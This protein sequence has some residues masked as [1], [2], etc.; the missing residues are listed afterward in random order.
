MESFFFNITDASYKITNILK[1]KKEHITRV[2]ISNGIVYLDI[3]LS[4]LHVATPLHVENLD[5]M[6]AITV[7]KEGSISLKDNITQKIYKI[8]SNSINLFA[9]S[10]QNLSIKINQNEKIEMFILFIADFILKRYLSLNK[11]E[12]INILY[13]K[14]QKELSLELID[15]RPTDALSLYII[16]KILAS[17]SDEY[18]NSIKCEHNVLEFLIHRLS[19][20]DMIDNQE[21]S[22]DE[23][24]ISKSAK[25]ILLRSFTNPPSI[26]VL[27]HL[28]ATNETKLKST[29]K[30]AHKTTIYAY[31]QKLRLE[32]ANLLLKEQFLN[33]GQIAKEVGYKHQGH[34][35]KLFFEHFGVYPKDLLKK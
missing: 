27:A 29:F 9:S 15:K 25:D 20:I 12:I 1:N 24:Y 21:L 14:I 30:K 31:I 3:S 2:D 13:E 35:S 32:K 5:R 34:F 18:M 4:S 8:E 6:L 22:S 19:L 26:E 17:K 11:N 28:C 33:V 16:D 23:I 10:R 7:I